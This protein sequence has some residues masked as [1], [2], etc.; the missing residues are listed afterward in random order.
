MSEPV[1]SH[2]HGPE[3]IRSMPIRSAADAAWLLRKAHSM[4][5]KR[6]TIGFLLDDDGTGGKIFEFEHPPRHD[7]LFH[8][9][10]LL[11]RA[12]ASQGVPSLV[13][14]SVRPGGAQGHTFLGDLLPGDVDRWL[15]LNSICDGHGV[16][17]LD[18][19]VIGHGGIQ[20]P[21][22]LLGEPPRWPT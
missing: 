21:R 20:C 19:Y 22:D 8:I 12:G 9:A 2:D 16:R 3:I 14:A 10:D 7:L 13:L 18:W 4:P 1:E 6:A 15:E 11:A 17:L 5:L